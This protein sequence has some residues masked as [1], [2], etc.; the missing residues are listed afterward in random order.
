MCAV[1]EMKALILAN[2]QP[3]MVENMTTWRSGCRDGMLN[4]CLR[5][6]DIAW[7]TTCHRP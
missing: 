2:N 4:L 7:W 1:V 6:D 3:P 5:E